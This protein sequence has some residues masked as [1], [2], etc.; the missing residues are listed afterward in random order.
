[1]SQA[2]IK[3][4]QKLSWNKCFTAMC[5]NHEQVITFLSKHTKLLPLIDIRAC[6]TH[7]FMSTAS[8]TFTIS[9]LL[10]RSNQELHQQAQYNPYFMYGIITCHKSNAEYWH[11]H[12]KISYWNGAMVTTFSSFFPS[13]D[14]PSPPP[15]SGFCSQQPLSVGKQNL[16]QDYL[17]GNGSQI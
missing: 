3:R 11:S 17:K 14:S 16:Q 10:S 9:W 15:P 5:M 4:L 12:S 13:Y 2:M 1:M 7:F 8:L 6:V